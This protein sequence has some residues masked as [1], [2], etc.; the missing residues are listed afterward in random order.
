MRTA[1]RSLALALL[2][3][4]LARADVLTVDPA[5]GADFLTPFDA[6]GQAVE[7]DV[8]LL[9]PGN[10][11]PYLTVDGTG[12]T[13]IAD[14]ATPIE[15]E[16]LTVRNLQQDSSFYCINI[17]VQRLTVRDCEG[18]VRFES[19]T[20]GG[21]RSINGRNV[22]FSRCVMQGRPG[23]AGSVLDGEPGLESVQSRIGLYDC[24]LIGGNGWDGWGAPWGVFCPTD[25]GPGLR[26]TG[27]EVFAMNSTFRGGDSLWNSSS[28]SCN[29]SS[30]TGIESLGAAAIHMTAIPLIAGGGGAGSGM[31]IDGAVHFLGQPRRELELPSIVRE[32]D[33]T[34]WRVVG[35]PGD[36]V[37]LA[38]SALGA[39]RYLPPLGGILA[40]GFTGAP[41]AT[42]LG[43]ID[44]SSEM[45]LPVN[46]AML[47]L[48]VESEVTQ[49]QVFVISAD[50]QRLLGQV[51]PQVVLN[52]GI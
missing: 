36:R 4:P 26:A 18:S 23:D 34:Q 16:N 20:L 38:S 3:S 22:V 8:I 47:P 11:G 17:E 37:F 51:S 21:A 15:I 45:L 33:A 52:A 28:Y 10:Y 5:G 13:L 27:G 19:C 42:Y 24:D 2:F 1:T 29:P 25:A 6:Y 43:M 12:I 35:R 9:R 50:G 48:G 14:S 46:V 39:W 41:T 49:Y 44:A 30:G 32:G 40:L 31:D 7:G